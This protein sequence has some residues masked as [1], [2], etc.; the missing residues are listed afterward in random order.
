MMLMSTSLYLLQMWGKALKKKELIN[1]YKG[2]VESC[3]WAA[4][5][6]HSWSFISFIDTGPTEGFLHKTDLETQAISLH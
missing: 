5:S 1:K 3:L 6:L 2:Y 4:T